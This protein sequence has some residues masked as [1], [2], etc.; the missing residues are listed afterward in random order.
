MDLSPAPPD[1]SGPVR[2]GG[3]FFL[4]LFI[5]LLV[6]IE[7]ALLGADLG[8]W[9]TVRLRTTVYDYTGSGPACFAGGG[10]ITPGRGP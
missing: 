8:L 6:A 2:T 10:P 4:A 7:L 9:A 3:T 1:G 5:G